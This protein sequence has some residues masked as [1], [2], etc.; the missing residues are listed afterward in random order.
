MTSRRRAGAI[1]YTAR[2][3]VRSIV[4]RVALACFALAPLA[5]AARPEKAPA[6]PHACAADAKVGAENLLALHTGND[7]LASIAESVTSAA[8]VKAPGGKGKLDVLKVTGDVYEPE[9][10]MRFLYAQ[11]R[12]MC[13]LLE[14]SNER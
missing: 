10:R 6:S 7:D 2:T 12:G 9:Y 5:S 13:A 3:A 14:Q 8:R 1:A 11:I 4:I